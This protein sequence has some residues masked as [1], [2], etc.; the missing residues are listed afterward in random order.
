MFLVH[1]PHLLHLLH[2]PF[3]VE[4]FGYAQSLGVVGD[5]DVLEA[6]LGSFLRHIGDGGVAVAPVRVH[7]EV[8]PYFF[9]GHKLRESVLHGGLYLAGVLPELRRHPPHAQSLVDP[10]LVLGLHELVVVP[11]E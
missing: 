9:E 10:G 11:P 2:E 3:L 8:A 5:G 7:V 1:P 4:A 6:H